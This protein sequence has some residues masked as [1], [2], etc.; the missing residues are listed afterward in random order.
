MPPLVA[1]AHAI[2][3]ALATTPALCAIL[4]E[5]AASS[6]VQGVVRALSG[7]LGALR[8]EQAPTDPHR[9]ERTEVWRDHRATAVL[10]AWL[11]GQFSDVH[12]HDGVE[13]VFRVM[14]GVAVER[15]YRSGQDGLAHFESEDRFLPG[16]VV[17]SLDNDIHALGNDPSAAETLV[18]LHVYR[19]ES[20][21]RIYR[22]A[23]GGD[24]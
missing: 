10:I 13:C 24:S 2:P 8:P 17:A 21:M 12:D 18:T 20:R 15:R 3:T 9:Y 19:P 22:C 11:P 23:E 14:H 4:R 16:S 1:A 6:S 5:A 7:D